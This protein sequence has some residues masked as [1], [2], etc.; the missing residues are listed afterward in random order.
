MNVSDAKD[1]LRAFENHG[2]EYVLVGALAMAAHGLIRATRDIGVFLAPTE[3]NLC[4]LTRAL[5]S[6]FDDPSIEEITPDDLL[7]DYPAVEYV[8]PGAAFSIDIMTRLGTA[9][10][11]GD[12]QVETLDF[13]GVCVKV[14]TP[15]TLYRMKKGTVRPQDAVDAAWLKDAY[16]VEGS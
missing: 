11:Y 1:I 9:F 6:L 3:E 4:R 7:G 10:E 13:D 16:G 12:L 5:H 15:S 14:A 8:P 2:V